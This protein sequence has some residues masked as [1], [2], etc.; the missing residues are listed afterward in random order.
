MKGFNALLRNLLLAGI[1]IIPFIPFV[2]SSSMF[3]PFITGKN[4]T[5]RILT[6]LLFAGWLI[7]LFSHP[8]YRP[9]LTKLTIAVLSLLGILTLATIFGENPYRSFW[10]NFERMEGL[11]TQ[12]HLVA[13][14]LVASAILSTEKLWRLFFQTSLL[15]SVG[16]TMYALAQISGQ[17]TINQSTVRVD[18]TMGNATYL[19]V[20][21]LFHVFFAVYFVVTSREHWQKWAYGLI[22]LGNLFM[23][24]KTGTRGT[25]LGLIG[26]ILVFGVLVAWRG[27]GRIRK[28]AMGV[29]GLVVLL[30]AVFL[31]IRHTAFVQ[32]SEVLSRFANI[33]ATDTTTQSRFLIWQM[34]FQGFKENPILGWGP[35]NYNLVFDKYYNPKLWPQEPWFDRSHN[36]FFDW[37]IN[38]GILG[39][40]AYLA[41][42]GLVLWYIWRSKED[43]IIKSLLTALLAGYFVHNIFVF[44]N[45]ISYIFFFSILAWVNAS[46]TDGHSSKSA[47]K[48]TGHQA[49]AGGS[50]YGFAAVVILVTVVA[51]YFLNYRPIRASQELIQGI[52]P[53]QDTEASFSHF[54]NVLALNTFGSGEARE[55]LL[56]AA[57]RSASRSDVPST[58]KHKWLQFAISQMAQG[59]ESGRQNDARS[60]LIFSSFLSQ[61]GTIDRVF[62]DQAIDRL[63]VAR[64]FSPTKQ[65]ILIQESIVYMVKGNKEKALELAKLAFDLEQTYPEARKNYVMIAIYAGRE[66]LAKELA[67]GGSDPNILFDPR[68]V[69]IYAERSQFGKIVEIWEKQSEL[70]PSDVSVRINLAGAY[71]KAGRR[72]E[73]LQG[74]RAIVVL[75]LDQELKKRVDYLIAEIEAGRDPFNF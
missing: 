62:Y 48:H 52:I 31:G 56:Q 71:V 67:S 49:K 45:L 38:A 51:V 28:L 30:V 13:Y 4:F 60:N 72:A 18:A 22:G 33:S 63:E 25:I 2:V 39:L 64:Q 35:E 36:V 19:A 20:Y 47:I 37:L 8:E 65:S 66:D 41:L 73:A 54:E 12:F 24:Y 26:G 5:F 69:S 7:L 27:R 15:A 58:L 34:S 17:L 9:K 32:N 75:N 57:I 50:E 40:A 55:Q 74:L 23:L 70:N 6:E 46:Y 11:I 42:F 44:D 53:N 1:F 29:I 16:M 14:F 3:F 43:L 59:I 61:L 10:S 68:L 21:A